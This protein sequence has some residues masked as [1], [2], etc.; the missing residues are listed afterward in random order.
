M[1]KFE[2]PTNGRYY[3]LYIERD[4][5]NDMVLTII[6]GGSRSRVV[7]RIDYSDY[8]QSSEKAQNKE[9]SSKTD[10][11]GD[12]FTD[13]IRRIKERRLKRGYILV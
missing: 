3:Y 1:L 10:G 5:L 7:Q 8:R 9:I 12:Q 11:K 2:N 4:L 13:R 6:R